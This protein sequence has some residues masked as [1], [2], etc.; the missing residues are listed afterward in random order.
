MKKTLLKLSWV[1]YLIILV[2]L[3]AQ[4]QEEIAE[5]TTWKANYRSFATKEN[6]LVH[7][8]LVA[9]FDYTQS[10]LNGEVWL[11][12]R[13][14]FYATAQLILDAKGM[15][16]HNVSIVKK[17][18]KNALKY[19]YDGNI[20]SID[21]DKTYTANEVYTIYI[22]YTAKPNEYK[23]KGSNAITDAKGLYF[24]NPL[25]KEKNKPTQIWT[26]GETEGTSVWIPIIDKPN[27]KCTQEFYLNVPSKYVSLSN[28][29]LVKQVA[30]KNGTRL[31]V[32]KMDLPH[33]PYLF[34]IGISLTEKNLKGNRVENAP[35]HIIRGGIGLAYRKIQL[36]LQGSYVSAFFTDAQ[37]TNSP[38]ANGQTGRI[39]SYNVFD[40]NCSF[41]IY[42]KIS[43][44]FSINNL[45]NTRYATRRS[46]GYPGP[47]LLPADGRTILSS[48]AAT[49]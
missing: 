1:L 8:K 4:A 23:A 18:T 26:Q 30:N 45:T 42:K 29:L 3:T 48:L 47:G 46:G 6:D 21:L 49:F 28:G 38:A 25:G 17:E 32:W 20:I 37:N 15:E 27:Q 7:T 10:Q 16:I 14:H 35:Q 31:D 22:K 40:L 36:N 2:T 13:P 44:R 33:S 12:L 19:K 24:I 9:N 5:D 11:Q 43:L 39:A 34:F 41:P